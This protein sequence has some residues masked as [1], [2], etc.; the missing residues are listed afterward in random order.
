[1]RHLLNITLGLALLCSATSTA[2]AQIARGTGSVSFVVGVYTFNEFQGDTDP[3]FGIRA[4]G[5][6]TKYVGLEGSFD[7][8]PTGE[9]VTVLGYDGALV[10]HL[11]PDKTA[12]PFIAA[13]IGGIT[14]T[15]GGGSEDRFAGNVGIGLKLFPAQKV[16]VRLEI[17]DRIY[18]VFDDLINDFH[19]TVGIELLLG[20]K[21]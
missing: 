7:V 8:I 21:Q 18:E 1:M 5:N 20:R 6:L 12:V 3:L 10:V 4:G 11:A 17:K 16:G 15:G 13:G 2:S 19:F 9:G 14:F